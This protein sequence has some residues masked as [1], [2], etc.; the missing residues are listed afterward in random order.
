VNLVD[1]RRWQRKTP[2]AIKRGLA[3]LVSQR[4]KIAHTGRV[5]R[6]LSLRIVRVR[7]NF[8]RRLAQALVAQLVALANDLYE[9][10]KDPADRA[11][12]RRCEPSHPHRPTAT[13]ATHSR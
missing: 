10:Q 2:A 11:A 7:R 1:G 4:G 3:A 5:T 9:E 12:S 8:V 6:P 13:S